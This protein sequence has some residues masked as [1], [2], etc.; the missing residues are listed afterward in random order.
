MV[1][2]TI[3]PLIAKSLFRMLFEGTIPRYIGDAITGLAF[4]RFGDRGG[5]EE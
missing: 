3:A 2:R 1:I 4:E 5:K